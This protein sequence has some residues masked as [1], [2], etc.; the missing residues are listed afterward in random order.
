MLAPAAVKVTAFDNLVAFS[1][2]QVVAVF[3][4][5]EMFRPVGLP[6]MF[7]VIWKVQPPPLDPIKV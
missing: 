1:V 4:A 3:R 6:K 7:C 2:I 5:M